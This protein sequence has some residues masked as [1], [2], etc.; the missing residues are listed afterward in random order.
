MVKRKGID[1][2]AYTRNGNNSAFKYHITNSAREEETFSIL[3]LLTELAS[4]MKTISRF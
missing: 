1:F 3:F 4:Q 2:V